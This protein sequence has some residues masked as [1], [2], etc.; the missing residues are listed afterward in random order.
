MS[1]SDVIVHV[2]N[3]EVNG[4]VFVLASYH[5]NS[6]FVTSKY[7]GNKDRSV[8]IGIYSDEVLLVEMLVDVHVLHE[9]RLH[10]ASKPSHLT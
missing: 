2:L 8:H 4:V 7:D 3:Q 5:G 1:S 9:T 10:I 6:C